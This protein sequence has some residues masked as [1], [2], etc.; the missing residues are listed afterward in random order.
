MEV[1]GTH[2]VTA[3][4]AG[5]RA[6]LPASVR[7]VSGPGCP[8]CVLPA[9]ALDAM[10]ALAGRRGVLLATFGDMVRV[11]GSASSL[12][13]ER[14][15]G[16]DV[17]V[18]Y[19]P[20]D[21]LALT[22]QAPERPVV[23]WGVG[24]ETTAPAVAWTIREA[25]AR[26]L[27]RFSVWCEHRTMPSALAALVRGGAALD[28]LLLPGHV[29]AIIGTRPYEFIAREHGI[30][31]VVAGFEPADMLDAL[32][33]LLR[34]RVEGRALVENQY[35]RAVAP[36]GNPTAR[37]MLESVF[38]PCD[39]EWRG[40][41]VIPASGLRIRAAFRAHDAAVAA[42]PAPRRTGRPRG[43]HRADPC[44]CGDVLRGLIEPPECPLYGRRCTPEAPAGACMV[45]GEG[46]CAAWFRYG[47]AAKPGRSARKGTRPTRRTPACLPS[48]RT[49]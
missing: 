32:A 4:R 19:S 45:S 40:L 29:S 13:R 28:G 37:A 48:D 9:A 17:R 39:A 24:F 22:A 18:V 31:C 33:R 35:G 10:L 23:F 2:T 26:G 46:A 6:L 44:R 38:E 7:L 25:A 42:G 8:V 27:S 12:E 36:G 5:L 49:T 43:S 34:Q 14:A 1:C 15:R 47:A 20:A 41:G 16:A 30:P 3:C 11:P 21:A